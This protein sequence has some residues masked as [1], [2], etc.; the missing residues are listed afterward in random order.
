M[1]IRREL[2]PAATPI[3]IRDVISGVRGIFAG[4]TERKRFESELKEHFGAKHCFLVSSGKAAFTLILLALKELS[5]DRNEVLIPAFTC[6]SVPSS[7]VR[8]GLKVRLCDLDPDRLDFDFTQLSTLHSSRE[9]LAV[10][11]T[12]L[13]GFPADVARLRDSVRNPEIAV[14]EDAAQAMGE[15][16][17]GTKVGTLGDVGF[18]SLGRG[19]PFSVVEGGIILTNRDD[20]ASVLKGLVDRLPRYGFLSLLGVIARAV[21]LMVLVHPRFFWLPRSMPFLRLGE[22]I[23]DPGF[24][25]LRMSSFQAGLARNWRERL[26]R[27]RQTRKTMAGEWVAILEAGRIQGSRLAKRPL[28]GL[29][30]FPLRIGD[31]EK[32]ANLLREGAAGGLGIMPVYPTSIA[33]IPELSGRV[34]DRKFP[35]AERCAGEL[36]TLPTHAYLTG[37]DVSRIGRL[38][39]RALG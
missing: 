18:F 8:A 38:V 12:H 25:M 19:K 2:P 9:V 1:R 31:S 32:R 35:V 39:I 6:F 15:T 10:V 36:V 7:I 27:M 29:L 26:E 4:R 13:F 30:R 17:G 16:I 14:V 22:T 23:F 21:A 28:P 34:E 20:V 33:A 11:P 24:R 37:E 5:P 3:G